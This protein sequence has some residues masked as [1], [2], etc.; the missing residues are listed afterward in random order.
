MWRYVDKVWCYVD[1]G[2]L[3]V[4]HGGMNTFAELL[5]RE[6]QEAL[7]RVREALLEQASEKHGIAESS[8]SNA[9][10]SQPEA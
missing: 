9:E 3:Q 8:T 7:E 4:Y 10:E 1:M 5:S 2:G 6:Q